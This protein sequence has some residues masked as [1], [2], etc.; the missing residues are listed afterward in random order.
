MAN[1]LK[2]D[3]LSNIWAATGTKVSPSVAKYGTG[4]IVE[5]PP[6]QLDNWVQWRQDAAIAHFNQ[7]GIPAWDP[8]TEYQ[9]NLSYTQGSNGVIYRCLV[10]NTNL[11]PINSFN[12]TYWERA[13]ESFGSVQIVTDALAVMVAN[14]QSLAEISNLPLARA[15][16]QVWSRT[17]ADARFASLVGNPSQVF[18]VSTAVGA[19]DAIPLGQLNTLLQQATESTAGVMKI[20]TNGDV[21]TGT[22]DTNAVTPLKAATV[23]L[24]KAGNLAGLTSVATARSNL[25]LG[26]VATESS[27]SFL[28]ASNNLSDVVNPATARANLG[29]TST[30]VQPET[31]FL[32]AAGNLSDVTD[33]ATARSNLGLT[34]L[35]VTSSA[36][37]MFKSDN[38]SGINPVTARTNL[39]LSDSATLP[40]TTWMRGSNNLSEISNVQTARNNLGLGSLAT[41]NV[42]GVP[43]GDLVFAGS[44]DSAGGGTI[45]PDGTIMNWG[46]ITAGGTAVFRIPFTIGYSVVCQHGPGSLGAPG[47]GV[48]VKTLTYF[49]LRDGTGG[50]MWQAIGK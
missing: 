37:V 2:P 46:N 47:S 34:S 48:G 45:L 33:V 5:T 13:F 18:R 36:L 15:N 26:S 40:S 3:G 23:Y 32:R 16:L 50:Y 30:A 11:D 44:A 8:E 49:T 24:S 27:G 14:Y 20:A 25:G 31:Y 39:G 6:Y 43:A 7:H 17:E 9:G 22:N 38:L 35:A 42:Y 1:I 19:D 41:R 21:A 4:W 10:T 12:S 28:R 29:L